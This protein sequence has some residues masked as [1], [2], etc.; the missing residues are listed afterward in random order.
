MQST[1]SKRHSAFEYNFE[2]AANLYLLLHCVPNQLFIR[3]LKAQMVQE[4]GQQSCPTTDEEEQKVLDSFENILNLD[5]EMFRDPIRA[6]FELFV[7]MDDAEE[8]LTLDNTGDHQKMMIRAVAQHLVEIG[9][10]V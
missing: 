4:L 7:A 8:E 3:E 6:A 9:Q 1:D 2:T 10:A 5:A